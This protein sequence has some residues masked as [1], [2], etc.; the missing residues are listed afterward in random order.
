[1]P[2]GCTNKLLGEYMTITRIFLTIVIGLSCLST[3]AEEKND[4]SKLPPLDLVVEI[5]SE[6]KVWRTIFNEKAIEK[7]CYLPD[8]AKG[9]VA[10]DLS[11]G[12]EVAVAYVIS[13][14]KL[15]IETMPGLCDAGTEIELKKVKGKYQG[16][17]F[18]RS[19]AGYKK[20]G[21]MSE[22]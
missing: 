3:I 4:S 1:M 10:I 20:I 14:N 7:S 13:S 8:H 11:N 6:K 22:K 9:G 5:D 15:R 19:I 21:T 17:L 12:R 16:F 18:E 2:F